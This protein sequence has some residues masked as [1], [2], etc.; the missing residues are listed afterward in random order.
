MDEKHFYHIGQ[1]SLG[2][3]PVP[4]RIKHHDE[5]DDFGHRLTQLRE[6]AGF[7]QHALAQAVNV[8]QRMIAYYETENG[9]P[10]VAL[11]KKL[12]KALKISTDQLLGLEKVTN[13]NRPRDNSLWRRFTQVEKLPPQA[14][15]QVTQYLD[16]VLR[17]WKDEKE[18]A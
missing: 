9:N 10:P 7:T 5:P 15:R 1:N 17:A 4:K 12:A 18:K 11:L 3:M 6:A 13:K 16:T 14:R 8:S 2:E